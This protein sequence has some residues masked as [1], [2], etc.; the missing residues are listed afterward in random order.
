M[1]R[2]PMYESDSTSFIIILLTTVNFTHTSD[3]FGSYTNK[4]KY[5]IK[6]KTLC[7]S[8]VRTFFFKMIFLKTYLRI[9]LKG[10]PAAVVQPFCISH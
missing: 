5:K 4:I 10:G 6:T 1:Q 9:S 2:W 7:M 8:H 3:K